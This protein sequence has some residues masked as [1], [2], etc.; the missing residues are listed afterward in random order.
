MVNLNSPT[1]LQSE[2]DELQTRSTSFKDDQSFYL[3]AYYNNV[4]Y[5]SKPNAPRRTNK[6][7]NMLQVFADKLT[8]S[9]AKFPQIE[10]PSIPQ[11]RENSSI[12]E[13]I[14][15]STHDH[16]E[17]ETRWARQ[18]ADAALLGAICTTVDWD[19]QAQCVTL[20][21]VDPRFVW[22]RETD[23][24][25]DKIGTTWHVKPLL[26]SEVKRLYNV[27]VTGAPLSMELLD[28][29]DLTPP[30]DGDEYFAVITRSD[31]LT[32][33][34]WCGSKMLVKPHSH[35][36]GLNPLIIDFPLEP[37][38]QTRGKRGDFYLRKLVDLQ[39]EF[40]EYWRQ[41]ANIIRKLGNP[42]VYAKGLKTKQFQPIKDGMSL[43]GGFV[44]LTEN[45]ELGI[46][47]IPETAMI[48]NGLADTFARMR[49]AAFYPQS[50]F[51]DPVGANTSGDAVGMY[52]MPTNEMVS[53][54]SIPMA[55][56]LKKVNSL[57]L[58][59]YDTR[60][61]LLEQKTIHGQLPGGTYVQGGYEQGAFA[62]TFSRQNIS[63]N[64]HNCVVPQPVTPKDDIAH[65]RLW[66]DAAREG[67]VSRTTFYDK[68]GIRSPQDELEMVKSE[69]SDPALNPAGIQQLM[70]G[71]AQAQ[72]AIAPPP[73]P[74]VKE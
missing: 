27:D 67:V 46:L 29:F 1:S 41:R 21:R 73:T 30:A 44:G 59:Y 35:G 68:V 8:Y 32:M 61:P 47:S 6:G 62:V 42:T 16:N 15:Y 54:F 13:K 4:Y 64:Y 9:L 20:Q 19:F 17:S 14:L 5:P 60:L 58:R 72:N 26:K 50:T 56:H 2:F 7:V 28:F 23:A 52:F 36:L 66:L 48:D 57:I 55:A 53:T 74:T 12:R 69:Q 38:M 37:P 18:A 43:D 31:D 10:V 22:W 25:N 70:G 34:R 63:G 49:D 11:D 33:V 3:D 71:F 51:G 39:A 24:V 65:K 40:N 45:G